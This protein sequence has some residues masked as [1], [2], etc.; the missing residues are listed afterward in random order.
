MKI[1]AHQHFWR[2]DA[3]EH[4]WM[5]EAMGRLKRDLLPEDLEPLLGTA[6][7]AGTVAV[8]ARQNLDETEWLLTLS[9][10]HDFIRG[11]VGWIELCNPNVVAQLER[12]AGHPRLK[13]VRHVVH[14]EADPRFM[15]RTDFLRG[16][17]RLAKYRL[18]YDLLLFPLHLPVAVEVVSKFPEQ[19][20]VLDH[21]AKPD[22]AKGIFDPWR[23]DLAALAAF[24]NVMC[25]L[26]GLVT[27]A[28]WDD[29]KYEDFIPA[30]DHVLDVFGS[31]RLMIGSD[32]PVCT[33]ASDYAETMALVERFVAPLSSDER[34]AVLGGNAATFYGL[35][36]D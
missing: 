8:Q 3:N 23:E 29:A 12:F 13:G 26:S 9:D 35:D 4:V 11:V 2:Y 14:D 1:D 19:P 5:T 32:W 10:R 15:L 36:E 21:I 33:L 22:I 16:L 30:L 28:R 18:T 6:G 17:A 24:P 20:F 25:K 34:A 7:Y 31:K 27:E